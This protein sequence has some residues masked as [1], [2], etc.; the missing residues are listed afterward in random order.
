[1]S[2]EVTFQ[3]QPLDQGV[4]QFTPKGGAAGTFGGAPIT[5]GKYEIPAEA[6][7]DPGTYEVRITSPKGGTAVT[8]EMPGEAGPPA[9][10]RIPEEFNVKTTL[11]HTVTKEG[12][13][14][15]NVKIP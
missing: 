4:I 8:E 2:G 13:N 5:N 10:E 9:E 3:G 15:F 6:G 7:L 14:E 12:P 1:V 11:E